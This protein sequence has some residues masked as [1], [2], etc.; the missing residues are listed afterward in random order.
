MLRKERVDPFHQVVR[1]SHGIRYE[2]DQRQSRCIENWLNQRKLHG[3]RT[4]GRV[5]GFLEQ[6]PANLSVALA[7]PV[8][9]EKRECEFR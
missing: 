2:C 9:Q 1:V 4:A 5:V 6:R 7:L 3:E 8:K